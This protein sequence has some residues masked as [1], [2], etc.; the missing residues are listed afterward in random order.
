VKGRMGNRV[1]AAIGERCFLIALHA[2]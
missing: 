2:P 1:H